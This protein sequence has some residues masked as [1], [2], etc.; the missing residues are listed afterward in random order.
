M[1]IWRRSS[2]R[3]PGRT[4]EQTTSRLQSIRVS[5]EDVAWVYYYLDSPSVVDESNRNVYSN[6]HITFQV[7][8]SAKETPRI[9]NLT[10][11]QLSQGAGNYFT[12]AK[13]HNASAG[14]AGISRVAVLLFTISRLATTIRSPVNSQTTRP[15]CSTS[16][17][18]CNDDRTEPTE[19]F[20]LSLKDTPHR[21]KGVVNITQST[22]RNFGDYGAYNTIAIRD[23]DPA[24]RH[25]VAG[26]TGGDGRGHRWRHLHGAAGHPAG[27]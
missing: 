17:T 9:M 18:I 11:I 24:R 13:L 12:Y 26:R 22:P 20:R 14:K 8:L 4:T 6:D 5:V 15:V 21:W 10:S 25:R 1:I 16:C 19:Y 7:A 3:S 23:N 27:Q 2:I